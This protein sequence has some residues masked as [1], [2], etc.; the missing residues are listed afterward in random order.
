MTA[1]MHSSHAKP[2]L[3]RRVWVHLLAYHTVRR[4]G[5][6]AFSFTRYASLPVRYRAGKEPP[7]FPAGLEWNPQLFDPAAHYVQYFDIVLV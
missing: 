7:H 5:E 4:P 3:W 1:V 6:L 2:A